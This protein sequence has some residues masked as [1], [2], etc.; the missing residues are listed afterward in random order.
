MPI[1]AGSGSAATRRTGEERSLCPFGARQE[2]RLMALLIPPVQ[3]GNDHIQMVEARLGEI[4]PTATELRRD[5]RYVFLCFTNRCGSNFLANALGSSG[6]LNRAG[7]F[8]N[9]DAIVDNCLEEKLTSLPEYVNSLTYR[10]GKNGFLVSKL[11]YMHLEIL[12]KAGILDR[13]IDLSRFV[14]VERIDKLAQAISYDLAFQ[15]GKWTHNM[16][17]RR[18]EAE[19]EFSYGWITEIIE[20][21]LDQNQRFARFF[22]LNGIIPSVATYERFVEDPTHQVRLLG[23]YLGL[24]ALCYVPENIGNCSPLIGISQDA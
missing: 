20:A 18:S 13:I 19:L 3:G 10:E 7:E 5:I 23:P 14:L 12:G 24:P 8:F 16:P 11:S 21:I 22:A 1:A 2:L 17:T 6:H 9:W 4:V 15:T